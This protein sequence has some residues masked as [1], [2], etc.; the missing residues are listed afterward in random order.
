MGFTELARSNTY[1]DNVSALW[2]V[3]K[4]DPKLR[5]AVTEQWTSESYSFWNNC[6]INK[7]VMSYRTELRPNKVFVNLPKHMATHNNLTGVL[8]ERFFTYDSLLNLETEREKTEGL[9]KTTTY[10]YYNNPSPTDANYHIG[11]PKWEKTVSKVPSAADFW[12]ETSYTYQNNLLK[13]EQHRANNSPWVSTTYGYDSFGNPTSKTLSTAGLSSRSEYFGYSPDGRDMIWHKNVLGLTTS[14]EYFP[15]GA[16]KKETDP[17]GNSTQ[18]TY[19]GWNRLHKTTNYLG[20]VSEVTYAH[21]SNGGIVKTVNYPNTAP[22]TRTY[23]NAWGWTDEKHVQVSNTQWSKTFYKYDAAGRVTHESIPSFYSPQ[24]WNKTYYDLYGRVSKMVQA[25][26]KVVNTIYDGLRTQ[27]SDGTKTA[28]TTKNAL[29]QIAE[30]A[31]PG[32]TIQY[33]YHANGELREADYG[34]YVVKTEIDTWGRKSKLIDPTAG[35]FTYKHNTF[36]ELLEETAPKGKTV[37]THDSY[38][39]ITTKTWTGDLTHMVTNYV[40]DSTSKLLDYEQTTD[41]QN[42][43]THR[44]KSEYD[45]YKRLK[46]LHEKGT[47]ANFA[48]IINYD[49]YGRVYN[50]QFYAT[51]NI[52]NKTYST[53]AVYGYDQTGSTDRLSYRGYSQY[54][55]WRSNERNALGQLTRSQMG[56]GFS[57]TKTINAFGFVTDV[58]DIKGT[59]ANQK[60]L[61]LSYNYDV[62]RGLLLSRSDDLLGIRNQQFVYDD[63]DRLIEAQ[64]DT[65]N[66]TQTRTRGY[67]PRGRVTNDSYVGQNYTYG[68]GKNLYRLTGTELNAEGTAFYNKHK[69]RKITYNADRKPVEVHD[70]GNGRITFNYSHDGHRQEVWYGGEETDKTQRQYHKTYSRIAPIELIRDLENNTQ[71]FLTYV[72][73]DAYTAPVVHVKDTDS[74]K[75]NG[76]HYLHRDYLGSILAV[77]NSSG[78]VMERAHFGAWGD[79]VLITNR[80]NATTARSDSLTGRGFTGHEHFTEVGL[81]HMNGRMYDAQQGRFLSPD[82]HIQDPFNT[83]NF[84]RYGYVLNNPLSLTDP[85]GEF[86]WVAVA[87]GAFFGGASA[88]LQGGDFWDILGGMLIGGIAAG[89]GAGVGNL[90]AQGLGFAGTAGGFFGNAALS[91]S[92]FGAGFAVGFAGGFASGFVGAAGNALMKGEKFGESLIMGLK[93]GLFSGV[94][95]GVTAGVGAGIKSAKSGGDFWSRPPRPEVNTVSTLKPQGI[96]PVGLPKPKGSLEG[97]QPIDDGLFDSPTGLGIRNDAGG[98]GHY[99][100][101]RGNRL[102]TGLDFKSVD[103]QN[104]ISPID[105]TAINRIG[106]SGSLVDIYPNN[107]NIGFDRMQIL[108]VDSPPNMLSNVTRNIN[109]GDVIGKSLNLQ[110]LGYPSSVGPHVHLQLWKNGVKINPTKFFFK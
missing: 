23:Y 79:E 104:I 11:R 58:T 56:N 72:G 66:I 6:Y 44:I 17:Y 29:D 70:V 62:A 92:G 35:T 78:E 86:F 4:H 88:A 47:H 34:G 42:G 94:A 106:D 110:N 100:A 82:N 8:H 105:G 15:Y 24:K 14:Y 18:Y 76:H 7:T 12:T 90:A 65:N 50:E 20:R 39:R 59:S 74:S 73:G 61:D 67:D 71:K 22:D 102:H 33:R 83:Q 57:Q 1:G 37:F 2:N 10:Q 60:A 87:I 51:D 89:I 63:M 43:T 32:G 80:D 108:Y 68:S 19:D 53:N 75:P 81:I 30:L 31:D 36:G 103:G 98:L 28:T 16:L 49:Y 99:E 48:K 26:G 9:D 40:Y 52:S 95:A 3:S 96:E 38:G 97:L 91:V 64:H 41:N 5:G 45:D 69:D 55:L 25:N 84:N 54:E 107:P 13:T 93:A 85:S 27:V 101:S 46:K 109:A 77:S 21:R